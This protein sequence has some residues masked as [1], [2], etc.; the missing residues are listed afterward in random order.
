MFVNRRRGPGRR[1]GTQ[2]TSTYW[3]GIFFSRRTRLDEWTE[4]EDSA[5]EGKVLI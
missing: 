1:D 4:L 3:N 5:T 2:L